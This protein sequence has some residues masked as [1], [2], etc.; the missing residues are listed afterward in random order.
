MKVVEHV[1][2]EFSNKCQVVLLLIFKSIKILA[3]KI[4][5]NND[6][7]IPINNVVA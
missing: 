5:V 3:I 7:M 2:R 1:L 4:E 6:V